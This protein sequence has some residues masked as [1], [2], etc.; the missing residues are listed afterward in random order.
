MNWDKIR[1]FHVVA[2]SGSFTRAGE[3]LNLSQS[4]V[5]RQ[6]R[7]LEDSLRL[8]LFHRHARG[9]ILTEQ[10]EFLY[11]TAR[12][13]F[14]KLAMTEA[15]LT[16]SKERPKGR[17]RVT[18]TVGFG[19][20]WLTSHIGEF[21]DLYPEISV[22]LLV[23]DVDL[24]LSMREAD[25][26]IRVTAPTQPDLIQR[27]LF[28][29]HFGVY[30]APSY[31]NKFGTPHDIGDLA[32]HRVVTFGSELPSPFADIDWLAE[33]VRRVD[34][35]FQPALTVNNTYG[36]YRAVQTGIGIATLP[37]FLA[38]GDSQLVS[39]LGDLSTPRAEGFFVY[40]AELRNSQRIEVFRDFL[41]R[42]VAATRF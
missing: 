32:R 7:G 36:M 16:E 28:T 41:L 17:L 19:S 13:L 21:L 23:V 25:V 29:G 9:L 22:S 3:A 33:A 2:E 38:E 4:A 20:V 35:N 15:V 27:H 14:A 39:V 18:T 31:L 30:A 10:G 26:A 12:E 40:P 34:A 24:D 5:S 8:P 42:K 6:I 11:R 1:I 37:N